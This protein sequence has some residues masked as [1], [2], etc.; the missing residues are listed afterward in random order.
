TSFPPA[1][2]VAVSRRLAEWPAIVDGFANTARNWPCPSGMTGTECQSFSP[3][4]RNCNFIDV[5]LAGVAPGAGPTVTAVVAT[6]IGSTPFKSVG[7]GIRAC[8][9]G[10]TVQGPPV[11]RQSH[12]R[13]IRA[14][15]PG[16]ER[17]VT[18]TVDDDEPTKPSWV[19]ET[20]SMTR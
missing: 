2:S 17:N 14:P 12:D 6:P 5:I 3:L 10:R 15:E 11:D 13:G 4:K 18:S 19:R 16:A 8:N 9:I 20:S 7:S 1:A